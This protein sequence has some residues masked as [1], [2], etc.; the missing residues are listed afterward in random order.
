MRKKELV[1]LSAYTG[2]LMCNFADLH[3]YIEEILERPVSTH[4]LA[5]KKLAEEIKRKSKKDFL[6]VIT[7][8]EF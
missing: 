8:C 2:T 5:S 4:E 3:Q 6:Q 1:I 7:D